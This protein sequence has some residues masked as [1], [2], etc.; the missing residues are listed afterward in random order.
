[1]KALVPAISLGVF[2]A[3]S[4]NTVAVA[5]SP[6]I[7]AANASSAIVML[8][9]ITVAQVAYYTT[10]GNGGYASSLTVLATP[11]PGS[12]DSF[13]PPGE[14]KSGPTEKSGYR[15]GLTAGAKSGAGPT[16]CAGNKTITK[17]YA[18]A[19]PLTLGVTGARS[20][21]V[22]DS[23]TIWVLD[24]GVAPKEP[25]GPPAKPLN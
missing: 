14:W 22:N 24:G 8:K 17:F 18:T 21:A 6:S 1:M 12:Q 13:L 20:F 16:D 3:L 19:T 23:N 2:I 9:A 25:F 5:Q 15:F 11:P 4:P 10:C 7:M